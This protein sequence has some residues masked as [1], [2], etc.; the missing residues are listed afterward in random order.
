[1]RRDER[2]KENLKKVIGEKGYEEL[3]PE[4]IVNLLVPIVEKEEFGGVVATLVSLA[5][6]QGAAEQGRTAR[7]KRTLG[8]IAH[9]LAGEIRR[10][11]SVAGGVARI[12]DSYR[13]G[14]GTDI[15]ELRVGA[16]A[17][18]HL[19]SFRPTSDGDAVLP[20]HCYVG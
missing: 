9:D 17:K 4:E 6:P 11:G 7:V 20:H 18:I 19:S 14:P 2:K 13:D 15:V 8:L 16:G 3:F 1:M 5:S 12:K 10:A